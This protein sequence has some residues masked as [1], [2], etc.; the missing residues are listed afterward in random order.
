MAQ[1]ERGS[2]D[3]GGRFEIVSVTDEIGR[4]S[5]PEWLARAEPVHRQLRSALPPDYAGKMT[6]VFA[7]GGRMCV[8]LAGGEVVG[9]AVYRIH[10]NTAQGV[11]LYV[12]DLV[13]DEAR[14]S[15]GVGHALLEHLEQMA[16]S[17]RCNAIVLDSGTDR[18]R[19]HRF[20]FREGLA[21]TSFH[22]VKKVAG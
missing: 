15:G 2:P 1:P 11:H 6:R 17:R 21:V 20:Y 16:R 12:D 22:F 8:A 19:S 5:A 9:V 7:D 18:H 4:V 10:E 13:T 14:R 3:F